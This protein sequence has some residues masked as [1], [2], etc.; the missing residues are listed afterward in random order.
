MVDEFISLS[1]SF[2][3]EIA[4][5]SIMILIYLYDKREWVER[6]IYSN[7][8]SEL[9]PSVDSVTQQNI[10]KILNKLF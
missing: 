3:P 9:S 5:Y 8:L 1:S 6:E 4:V 7:R 10:S 2:D